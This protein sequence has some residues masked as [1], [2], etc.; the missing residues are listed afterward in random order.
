MPQCNLQQLSI[1][2]LQQEN[3]NLKLLQ[4]ISILA[5]ENLDKSTL[6]HSALSEL[7]TF[8]SVDGGGIYQLSN[9]DSPRYLTANIGIPTELIRDLQKIPVGAGLTEQVISSGAPCSW[10]DLRCEP[11]L[12]CL[13][14][15]DEGWR[16]VVCLPLNSSGRIIG[17]L[18]L[19]QRIQRQF[20]PQDFDLLQQV[21]KILAHAL[22]TAELVDKL[23]WQ[24]KMADAG[25]REQERSRL[26]LRAHLERLEES[27]SILEKTSRTRSR[28]LGLASHELRTP[29]TCV[30][31]AIELLQ[32]KLPDATDD[33]IELMGMLEQGGLRLQTLIEDLLEM[34]RIE[35][36]DLYMASEPLDLSRILTETHLNY[37]LR[38]EQQQITLSLGPIPEH[39]SLKGDHHHLRR[40]LDRLLDNA[41]KFSPADGVIQIKTRL[42]TAVEV[43]EQQEHLERFCPDL[44]VGALSDNYL[45]LQIIDNGIGI[46]EEER[47]RIFDKF[48]GATSLKHHGQDPISNRTSGAGLG[49]PLAKGIIEGHN[50]MIWVE[51]P[52]DH[53][54]GSTFNILL[55]LYSGE[56]RNLP[57]P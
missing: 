43:M 28:F 46:D 55:P 12:H 37:E 47:I 6:L 57:W 15:L 29:L 34:A 27:H 40:A 51:S 54:S 36:G 39:L 5:S 10:V 11:N 14:V 22:A 50:G 33:I 35:S 20:S 25:Q 45:L 13:A 52:E 30:L 8:F 26:Q 44:F 1:T 17:I 38:S 31:S 16:S 7:Q 49:L 21:G 53:I 3:Q 9:I 48:H 41:C 19:F 56:A 4:R 23:E 2:D 42:F 24:Q 18:F 32:I